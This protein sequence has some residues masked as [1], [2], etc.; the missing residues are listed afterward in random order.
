[1]KLVANRNTQQVCDCVECHLSINIPARAWDVARTK[2][3]AK[4][5]K[6]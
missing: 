6:R 4:L 3:E 1:M 2:R 5:T